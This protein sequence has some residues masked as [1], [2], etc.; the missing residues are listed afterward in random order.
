MDNKFTSMFEMHRNGP[1]RDRQPDAISCEHTVRMRPRIEKALSRIRSP[2]LPRM[3]GTRILSPGHPPMQVL[4]RDLEDAVTRQIAIAHASWKRLNASLVQDRTV[5]DYGTIMPDQL[6]LQYLRRH[7]S[8]TE[9][10]KVAIH[11][12]AS[13]SLLRSDHPT[14]RPAE[15]Y[16]ERRHSA[17]HRQKDIDHRSTIRSYPDKSGRSDENVDLRIHSTIQE[18]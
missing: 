16:N 13:D 18:T 17:L 10:S 2:R 15:R 5:A 9:G 11:D 12:V 8:W 14:V 7:D 3:S 6:A 1:S 4:Y